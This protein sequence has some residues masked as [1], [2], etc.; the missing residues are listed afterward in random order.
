MP[1]GDET[2]DL[3]K[4]LEQWPYDA[5]RNVRVVRLTDGRSVIQARLPFGME[6]YELDGRP[7]GLRPG[8]QASLLDGQLARLAEARREGLAGAFRLSR[9]DCTDLF[10][11]GML[12][13]YRYLRLFEL[14]DWPRT[15]RDAKRNIR[16]FD[17]VHRH[18]EHPEDR[19]YLEQWRPH[20]TRVHAIAAAM[21]ELDRGAHDR[22]LH[23]LR[24]AIALIE[25]LPGTEDPGFDY[26]TERS[27]DAL[28]ELDREIRQS[29]PLNA[30]EK[31][32]RQMD[33]AIRRED[34]EQAARI[35]DRMTELRR[36][37]GNPERRGPKSP[38][39]SVRPGP[40]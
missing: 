32:Q 25:S 3:R 12:Y 5:E 22:A 34:F 24:R 19:E 9:E 30:E 26:E 14:Q 28:R 21:I 13:Y 8:G 33:R 37:P 36:L 4:W 31:L 6:Q 16:L 2:F 1:R 15:V 35:R 11:E 38:S 10:D 18:A 23:I 39:R 40:A 20:V 29:R 27:L 17:L 7:D